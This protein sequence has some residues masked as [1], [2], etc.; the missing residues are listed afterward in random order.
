M[1]IPALQEAL[2]DRLAARLQYQTFSQ[3]QLSLLE[4][5]IAYKKSLRELCEFYSKQSDF[6]DFFDEKYYSGFTELEKEWINRELTFYNCK[7]I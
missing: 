1:P 4:T 3:Q 5:K 7:F 2:C 6:F